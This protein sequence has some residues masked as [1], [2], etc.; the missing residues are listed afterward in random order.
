MPSSVGAVIDAHHHVWR[1]HELAWLNGPPVE[2]IFGAYDALRR[3]FSADDYAAAAR[4]CGVV[5]SVYVQANVAAGEEI[6]EVERIADAGDRVGCMGAIVG[7]ANLSDAEVGRVLDAQMRCGRLR[8]IRQQLHW[9]PR[10]ALS[11]APRPDVML[12][13][14]WLRGFA[15]L[16]ARDLLFELQV[17]PHQFNDALKLVDRFPDTCFVLIHAGMLE[18]R[19]PDGWRTWRDGLQAMARRANVYTK[20]SGL[21][22]FVRRCTVEDFKP[23]IQQTIEVFGP[24][25]CLF[26]SNYPIEEIWSSLG[27]VVSVTRDCIADL[28]DQEQR[29]VMHDV[30]AQVYRLGPRG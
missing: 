9:H 17:F 7:Y 21:G 30:A 18:D 6:A 10:S 11:F 24:E 25:R 13:G 16:A 3:D 27:E 28:S 26:G 4:R 14:D 1:L 22:T 5:Q 23:V 15:A 12:D 29:L 8:G 2:R 20:L 19:S